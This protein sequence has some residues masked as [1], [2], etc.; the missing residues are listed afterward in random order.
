VYDIETKVFTKNQ[1]KIKKNFFSQKRLKHTIDDEISNNA[2]NFIRKS[3]L[4][5]FRGQ[6]FD[7][8]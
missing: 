1:A 4:E 8:W 6:Q 2:V 7:P 5:I 3:G